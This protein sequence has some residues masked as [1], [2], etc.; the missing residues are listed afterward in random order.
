MAQN[1]WEQ[2]QIAG[3]AR[4]PGV[5]VGP[6]REAAP[7]NPAAEQRDARRLA[8]AEESATREQA[9][10]GRTQSNTALDNMSTL[11]KEFAGRK[12]VQ[13]FNVILPQVSDA[14]KIATNPKATG[15][16]DLSLIYTFGKVMDPGSVVREG[17]LALA[18]DTGSFAQNI[19]GAIQK[20]QGGQKLPPEIRMNLVRSM[21]RRGAQ[22]AKQ[23]N[24]ERDDFKEIAQRS[25]FDPELIVGRHPGGDFQQIEANFLGQPIRNRDGSMGA[26]PAAPNAGS[27]FTPEGGATQAP[28]QPGSQ[29]PP[30]GPD[31]FVRGAKSAELGNEARD[32]I[33]ARAQGMIREG[34]NYDQVASYLL[35][36]GMM[37]QEKPLR[38][39]TELGRGLVTDDSAGLDGFVKGVTQPIDRAAEGLERGVNAVFGTDFNSARAANSQRDAYF[40]ANPYDEGASTAG[41]IAATALLTAPLRS[42]FL[43]G[44]AGNVLAGDSDTPT[45]IASDAL[46]G[47]VGGKA[48]DMTVKAAA[49]ALAPNVSANV[50]LLADEGVELDIGQIAGRDSGTKRLM[51]RGT[52]LPI[53]GGRID[54]GRQRSIE[55]FNRAAANR[56]LKPIG[57]TVPDSKAPGNDVV[58]FV[59]EELSNEYQAILSKAKVSLDKTFATRVS[60]IR[61]RANL[62][63]DQAAQM[64]EI[65]KRELTTTFSNG[66]NAN[67]RAY[68]MLDERLGT[69]AAGFLEDAQNPYNRELGK[70]LANVREQ[71]GANL[72]RQN[73]TLAPRLKRV[74]LGWAQYARIRAAASQTPDGVFTPGQLK[75]AVRQL[76]G[77]VSKG[78]VARGDA[79]MQDLSSAGV[80]VL[81]SNIGN[82]GTADRLAI[83]NPFKWAIGAAASPLVSPGAQNALRAV[84]TRQPGPASQLAADLIRVL[85]AG[86]VGGSALGMMLAPNKP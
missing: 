17:E 29:I 81:P 85:P 20:V 68:K 2:D 16:D 21:Q 78:A 30:A 75:T 84:A 44:A 37:F 5:I 31:G 35:D 86:A 41:N 69:L 22:L 48:A 43:Q 56:A 7:V 28:T 36:K 33:N 83:T 42:A 14:M 40:A 64:D 63:L 24:R 82:S 70:A 32:A 55:T 25:G 74:D 47:G 61:G 53:A 38:E 13:D 9:N 62:P 58:K 8:L 10:S 60:A 1:W 59:E 57:K 27:L 34:A 26:A 52:T 72:R 79:L 67:G 23:Y 18:S 49:R 6:P 15:A 12:T 50:R 66:N 4:S 65:L 3:S 45:E 11:R 19:E 73:P 76:D 46:I 39:A 54:Q 80:D 51:D 71:L 77:S